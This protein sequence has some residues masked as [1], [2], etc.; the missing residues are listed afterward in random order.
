MD[1]FVLRIY[2]FFRTITTVAMAIATIIAM[3]ETIM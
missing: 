2:A 1:F 3:T